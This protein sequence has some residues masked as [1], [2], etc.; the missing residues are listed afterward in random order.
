MLVILTLLIFSNAPVISIEPKR[1]IQGSLFT[2]T[3]KQSD[4]PALTGSFASQSLH[5]S[6]ITGGFRAIA[7]VPVDAT[8]ALTLEI[9]PDSATSTPDISPETG[10]ARPIRIPITIAKG[11][12]RTQRLSVAGRFGREPDEATKARIERDA[13]KARQVSV[14]SHQTPRLWKLPFIKPAAGRVTSPFGT[15]RVFNGQVKSRHTGLDFGGGTG[16]PVKAA[17]DG[18]VALLDSFYLGGNCLYL[19]HGA[20]FVTGYLHLSKW[21]VKPGQQ[22]KKGQLIGRI[23]ATGRVTGPHLH[24][25][26]RYG[27]ISVNPL[28]LFKLSG[29]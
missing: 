7:A 27:T 26:A 14:N 19:D 25:I 12:Y 16:A 3:V 23:G 13:A 2:I 28:S 18:I 9:V 5:F 17:N 6:P 21:Y 20:G 22:V 8:G 1:P 4:S 11:S 24:F 29:L 15:A 10:L